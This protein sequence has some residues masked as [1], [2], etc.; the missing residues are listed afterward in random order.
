MQMLL[1]YIKFQITLALWNKAA[2]TFTGKVGDVLSIEKGKLSSYK[3]EKKITITESTVL[4]INPKWPE[5]DTLK[6]WFTRESQHEVNRINLTQLLTNELTSN[7][8]F[9]QSGK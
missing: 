9:K 8:T 3:Q 5:K 6:E 4:Q 2:S 1:S 7:N